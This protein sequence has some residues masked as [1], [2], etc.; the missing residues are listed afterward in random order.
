MSLSWSALKKLKGKAV[1]LY[2]DC[3]NKFDPT[4]ENIKEDI[5]DFK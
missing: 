2:L 5:S 3:Q 1:T 4:L